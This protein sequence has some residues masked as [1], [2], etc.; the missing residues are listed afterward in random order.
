MY[1]DAVNLFEAI[2]SIPYAA[3]VKTQTLLL[4]GKV[5]VPK[6][7]GVGQAEGPVRRPPVAP[8]QEVGCPSL[9]LALQ[10]GYQSHKEGYF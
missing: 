9:R 8:S 10:R 5:V 2:G 6:Q 1:F 3:P 7:M 4:R